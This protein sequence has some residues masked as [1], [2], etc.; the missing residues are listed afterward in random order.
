M[1]KLPWWSTPIVPEDKT[2]ATKGAGSKVTASPPKGKPG[3]AA[4]GRNPNPGRAG[5]GRTVVPVNAQKG[6]A[7]R[8]RGVGAG[9]KAK[10]EPLKPVVGRKS[11]PAASRNAA[12]AKSPPAKSVD[13]AKSRN[14]SPLPAIGSKSPGKA[15][16]VSPKRGNIAPIPEKGSKAGA[17]KAGKGAAAPKAAAAGKAGKAG[18]A[19][20]PAKV[21]AAE[22]PAAAS[23][24]AGD[25]IAKPSPDIMYQTRLGLAQ[26][27]N[28]MLLQESRKAPPADEIRTEMVKLYKEAIAMKPEACVDSAL[29]IVVLCGVLSSAVDISFLGAGSETLMGGMWP[30]FTSLLLLF[31]MD[32]G[33]DV[34]TPK[35]LNW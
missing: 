3:A 8:T 21:A 27:Q 14:T 11:L 22:G 28:R 9:A 10:I 16:T 30:S 29:V 1:S 19:A 25:G 7:G 17:S 32:R 13:S 18:K 33:G 24:A 12:A 5:K 26:V 4:G 23:A 2:A 35:T 6:P 31:L 20:S 15:S 34:C